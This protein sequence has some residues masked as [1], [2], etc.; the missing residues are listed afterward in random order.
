[1]PGGQL[2]WDELQP[3]FARIGERLDSIE[4]Q[5]VTVS[6]KLGVPFTPINSGVPAEVVELARAGK[7]IEAITKYRELTNASA[8]DARAVVMAL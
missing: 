3:V 8:P 1:M 2:R 5:L 4:A 6:E 7:T